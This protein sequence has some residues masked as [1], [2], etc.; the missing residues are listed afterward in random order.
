MTGNAGMTRPI[1]VQLARFGNAGSSR[2]VLLGSAI[3]ES[4]YIQSLEIHLLG[5][6]L[7]SGSD[8]NPHGGASTNNMM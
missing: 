5:T 3:I 8:G 7:S 4:T 2:G 1:P 6:Y